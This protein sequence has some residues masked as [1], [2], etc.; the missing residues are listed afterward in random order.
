MGR[1]L[2]LSACV[3]VSVAEALRC[4]PSWRRGP[5][6]SPRL[7]GAG[8]AASGEWD[9]VLF[10]PAKV[11]LFLRVLRKRED[12][13]HELASLFQAVDLGDTL[14]FAELGGGEG[15][16]DVLLCDAPGC[17]LD[18][19]QEL[20][21]S[22]SLRRGCFRGSAR[23]E[24]INALSSPREMIARPKMSQNE[25]E[26]TEIRASEVGQRLTLFLPRLD[27][28]NL[29]LRAVSLYR[30]KVRGRGVDVPPLKILLEKRTPIQAG[31]GGG[32]S[33]AATALYAANEL[34]GRA[35]SDAELIE[36]SGDLG[37]DVTFFLGPTGSCYC[38]G[39]GEVLEPVGAVA[40]DG[41]VF[42]V[43]PEM[44]L[45]TPLVFKTL[46]DA[47]Y[48]TLRR[49][50]DP[51]DLLDAF[52]APGATPL[53]DYVNDLEPPAFACEPQL[54]RLKAKLLEP[55]YAFHAAMMSG[56]G[57][58]LFAVATAGTALDKDAFKANF[59]ADAKADLG[60]DVTVWR[61]TFAKREAGSWYAH[62]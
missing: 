17:P 51:R 27:P 3:V 26:P 53:A 29:V 15:E 6:R 31:L 55:P 37:S 48:A 4:G 40:S 61:T 34:C 23:E 42:I 10:S 59:E 7:R 13:F 39:R 22:T 24:S 30:S 50:R 5:V 20:G 56:S 36:W 16:D 47:D 35:A 18:P 58:S 46:A 25:W 62:P 49:D 45:S 8:G 14:S 44:G 11:N 9:L 41:D 57:T 32:S 43:K 21:N 60:V 38:T 2:A 1:L 28:S 54:E 12:G 19:G 33:N 52:A